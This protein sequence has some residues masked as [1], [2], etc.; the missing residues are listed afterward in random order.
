MRTLRT[1][2]VMAVA[3]ASF[4]AGGWFARR[5]GSLPAKA[6]GRRVLYYHDPMHPAYRSDKP[7]VAPDC[8]M[9]L[10]P[11]YASDGERSAEVGVAGPPRGRCRFHRSGSSSWACG[12]PTSSG[13]PAG[14]RYAPS[15]ESHLTTVAF[16]AS[17]S[18]SRA[19]CHE[20]R[21]APRRAASCDAASRSPPW[22][23]AT[24]SPR[25][26]PTST[27]SSR[28]RR[29]RRRPPASSSGRSSSRNWPRRG[30]GSRPSA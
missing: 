9:R 11:V 1:L 25:S 21:A 8:G 24:S 19:G 7:G 20:W 30:R 28:S 6:S 23:V 26:R 14:G 18:G 17:P 10:A 2:A 12:T 4:A 29:S 27:P 5:D 22:R 3:A 16:T 13:A 15:G